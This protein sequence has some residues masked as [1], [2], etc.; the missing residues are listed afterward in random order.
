[1]PEL[2]SGLGGRETAAQIVQNWDR[3]NRKARPKLQR[4]AKTMRRSVKGNLPAQPGSPRRT[5]G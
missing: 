3:R 2:A 5:N 1:M 4:A